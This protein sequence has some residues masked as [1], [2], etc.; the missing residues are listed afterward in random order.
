MNYLELPYL[1]VNQPFDSFVVIS[2][3]AKHLLKLCFTDPLRY[4]N[5]QLRGGQRL[6][7]PS[8]IG[9]IENFI[10]G[11]EASFPNSIILSA[12]YTEE[13]FI[14]Q[15]EEIRWRLEKGK[16]IIP[17]DTKLASIIDGQHRLFGFKQL[18]DLSDSVELVCSIYF[19][20]PNALQAYLFATIN[21]NQTKVDKSLAYEQFGFNLD[22]EE[23][24]SWS[25]DKL[26]IYLYRKLNKD[27]ESPFK[28]HIRISA[29]VD[30]ELRKKEKGQN[31]LVSAATIVDGILKLISTNPKLDKYAL[32]ERSHNE[33][34]RS[35]LL[36][37]DK[38]PLRELYLNYSDAV[39][40]KVLLNFFSACD[41]V[42]FKTVEVNNSA[43][44]KTVGIQALFDV[45]FF[46]INLKKSLGQS[47]NE[48]D[49]K[50]SFFV[51]EF[52]KLEG[53]DFSNQ[54]FQFSG[55]GKNRIKNVIL[56]KW[57]YISLD[58][59]NENDIPIY[60]QLSGIQEA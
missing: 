34:K 35:D 18:E 43:I 14:T 12:N 24:H 25:P 53:I 8:R 58:G 19:D 44:L 57:G 51:D 32:Q 36:F 4:E 11:K 17:T 40:Y 29:Q 42:I 59:L 2:V 13:G 9:E 7:N 39:L 60:S 30:E 41:M 33:R 50:Y 16:L 21:S 45:L 3:K 22:E 20:L 46:Y 37:M 28:G 6:I 23:A 26:A 38:S 1:E 47:L 27:E 55:L 49:F 52:S 31:W 5:G 10:K 15:D 48:I 54:F 56:L